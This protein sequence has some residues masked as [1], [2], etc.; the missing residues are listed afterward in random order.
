MS[1]DLFKIPENVKVFIDNIETDENPRYHTRTILNV[2]EG[3][4][5]VDLV[6]ISSVK[7]KPQIQLSVRYANTKFYEMD[8]PERPQPDGFYDSAWDVVDDIMICYR[9]FST[10]ESAA[11]DTNF[12]IAN[13]KHWQENLLHNCSGFDTTQNHFP[14]T[15][16][17]LIK[18]F[19]SKDFKFIKLFDEKE[20][21]T[22]NYKVIEFINN[23]KTFHIAFNNHKPYCAFIK[24]FSVTNLVA[25]FRYF[26]LEPAYALQ[27]FAYCF[28]PNRLEMPLEGAWISKL[29]ET[30]LK[31][32]KYWKAK[33]WGE[34]LFNKWD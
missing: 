18:I 22:A 33:T 9:E 34:L 10:L 31:Q 5:N 26:P 4:Y 19:E 3:D 20:L 16:K 11:E 13:F 29:S 14:T 23:N 7:D 6:D 8:D 12:F 1:K 30:E 25:E 15:I 2:W 21:S 32:I 27:N 17:K 24:N 28:S